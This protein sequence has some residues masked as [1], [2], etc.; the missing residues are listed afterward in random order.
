MKAVR[1]MDTKGIISTNCSDAMSSSSGGVTVVRRD[2]GRDIVG[3]TR[4]GSSRD[5]T[6]DQKRKLL[7]LNFAMGDGRDPSFLATHQNLHCLE[8]DIERQQDRMRGYHLLR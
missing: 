4:Q 6:N 5:L 8:P 3:R 2:C 7:N 1:S